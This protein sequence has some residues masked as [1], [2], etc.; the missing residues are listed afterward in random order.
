MGFLFRS[1]RAW[2]ALLLIGCAPPFALLGGS[3]GSA[4]AAPV[5]FVACRGMRD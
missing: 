2:V 3:T 4:A 1:R 5:P